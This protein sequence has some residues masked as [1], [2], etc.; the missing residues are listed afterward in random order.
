MS[1]RHTFPDGFLWGAATAAHQ[2]E[3][4]NLASDWWRRE[5]EPGT[6]IEQRSG[7]ACDSYHRW[8]QDM[9][10]VADS[11]LAGY[12]FSVEWARIEPVEGQFSH[13]ELAHYR[14]MIQYALDRGIEPVVTLHHF[15]VPSWFESL[16][17]FTSPR[18]VELFT[19]Y[20][21]TVLPILDGVTWV[22]TINEPN[23]AAMLATGAKQ[24]DEGLVS[25][26][27]PAPDLATRDGLLAC[28]RAAR[29][30]LR[31]A[32]Y[33]AGWTIAPQAVQAQ[34]GCEQ[35]AHDYGY[36]R[37]QWWLEQSEGDDWVGVQS[38]T[39]NIVGPDGPLPPADDVETTLTGWEYYPLALKE[40]IE[41]AARS[42]PTTPLMVTENG[43]ATADDARRIDYTR[44]ALIGL[45]EAIEAGAD[46]RGY[47]HWSL[48]DNYEWGS[49]APTFGLVAVDP[50]T[51]ER[52]A[53]PSLAWLGQ[54]SRTNTVE[55]EDDAR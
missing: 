11:G 20:V 46:V 24:T 8:Q 12:R 22:C 33:R 45:H 13:A 15:T 35:Q 31:E 55:S 6:T 26:G 53:R 54:V 40:G 7:D 16:G 38:Y 4:N 44:E 37:D 19:R 10:L 27:L 48:L 52:T 42:A 50:V 17:S 2:I 47:L 43:M 41:L 25:R 3:G 14:A 49:F 39:R 5:N 21:R 29:D 18:A 9:D 1:T 23:I 51:F 28:H 30:L 36:P 32:G 34:P